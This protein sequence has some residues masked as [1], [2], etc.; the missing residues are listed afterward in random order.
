MLVANNAVKVPY[1]VLEGMDGV[2]KSSL[3]PLVANALKDAGYNVYH[4]QEPS[5]AIE[6]THLSAWLDK[7]IKKNNKA[8]A[9][10]QFA[11]RIQQFDRLRKQDFKGKDIILADRSYISTYVYQGEVI[12]GALLGMGDLPDI[13]GSFHIKVPYDTAIE[14]MNKRNYI[15]HNDITDKAQ[16]NEMSDRYDK[17]CDFNIENNIR[18]SAA[19]QIYKKIQEILIKRE[20]I[21][22]D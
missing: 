15:D 7:S 16:Y 19:I 5:I 18:L 2:G 20:V 1:F 10:V 12:A 9:M 17:L 6:D 22:M 8:V 11:S 14:R 13:D 4:V 21:T 3:L